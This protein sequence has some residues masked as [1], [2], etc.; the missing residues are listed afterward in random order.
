VPRA[1]PLVRPMSPHVELS[2]SVEQP[3]ILIIVD[4]FDIFRNGTA[5]RHDAEVI[6][7]VRWK[8]SD[9]I[10]NLQRALAVTD[11]QLKRRLTMKDEGMQ[12]V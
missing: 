10:S 11:Q 12:H 9:R 4:A 3:E 7:S 2:Q 8:G 6:G 1:R 5:K